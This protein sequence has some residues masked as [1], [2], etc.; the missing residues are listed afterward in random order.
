MILKRKQERLARVGDICQ[1][2]TSTLI[3]MVDS[4]VYQQDSVVYINELTNSQ[5]TKRDLRKNRHSNNKLLLADSELLFI[6]Q[7]S[8][9]GND[10]VEVIPL[11]MKSDRYKMGIRNLFSKTPKKYTMRIGSLRLANSDVLE[12]FKS[13]VVSEYIA[14]KI[15]CDHGWQITY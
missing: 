5:I 3:K 4:D 7:K 2:K 12:G 13:S 9:F 14:N 10:L 6:G 1:I 15:R 8:P 11:S